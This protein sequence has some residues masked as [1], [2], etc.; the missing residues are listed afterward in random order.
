MSTK[1]E[2]KHAAELLVSEAPG[3][4]SRDSVTVTVPASTTLKAGSVLAQLSATGKYVPYDNAGSDGSEA[5]AAVLFDELVNA[6]ESGA[7]AVGVVINFAA[8]VRL[9]DLEWV[10]G[11]DDAGKLAAYV[12]LRT[13]GVKAR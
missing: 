10:D 2:G 12:D 11:M 7:D 8:E 5:A 3:T 6:T 13:K 1:T 9:S 4:L